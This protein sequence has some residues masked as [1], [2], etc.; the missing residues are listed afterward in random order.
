MGRALHFVLAG[1][2]AAAEEALAEAAR[3]DSSASDVYLAL[4]NVYRARGQ[5]GRAIQIHQ[6]L[7]LRPDLPLELHREALLGLALDFRTGGFLG[8]ATASFQELLQVDPRNLQ[9]LR[10]LERIQVEAGDWESAIRT[11]RAIGSREPHTPRVLA[12]L[13]TGLGRSCAQAGREADARRAFRRALGQDRGCAEAYL[14]LGDQQLREDAP[15]R[16]IAHYRRTL[17]LHPAIGL[18]AYPRLWRAHEKAGELAGFEAV[19]R[20]RLERRRDDPR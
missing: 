16:A 13:W 9:A 12:H 14:E 11:R 10:E 8:R 7:L 2:L 18:L 15:R 5:I 1:D 3:L 6:S 19:L 20:E 17:E 4:A